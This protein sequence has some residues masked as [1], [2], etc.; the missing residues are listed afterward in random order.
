MQSIPDGMVQMILSNFILKYPNLETKFKG[1]GSGQENSTNQGRTATSKEMHPDNQ[2][3]F[4][5]TANRR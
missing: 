1:A 3:V 2:E 5:D 4:L